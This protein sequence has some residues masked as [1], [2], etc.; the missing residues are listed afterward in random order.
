M[1]AITH[2]LT[3][4]L[5]AKAFFSNKHGRVGTAAV[6]IG[7]VFPDSDVIF[8]LFTANRLATME[9]HRGVT[10]SYLAL[11]LFAALLAGVTK[12]FAPQKKF[13]S[14][15]S[16]YALGLAVHIFLDLITSWGTMIWSPLNKTRASLDLV[17][18]IDFIFVALVLFPQV[19][20]WVYAVRAGAMRRVLLVWLLATVLAIGMADLATEL[21]EITFPW[22]P[23]LLASAAVAAVFLLP[24]AG[25]WGFRQPRALFCR[26]G[27]ATL[28]AY[29]A[30][31]SVNHFFALKRV[32]EF[33][34]RDKLLVER[35]A[36]LPMPLSPFSWT[37]LVLTPA[38]VYESRFS[39][40]SNA[41]SEFRF[42]PTAPP[43]RYIALAQ[44]VPATQ[45]YLWFARFPVVRYRNA[46][47][48]HIVEYADMR[49]SSSRNRRSPF[50]Y[51]VLLNSQG[52]VLMA[53]FLRR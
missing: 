47:E 51:R 23:V 20:A 24:C 34:A 27:V 21:A 38:G 26:I 7:A 13:L 32:E 46:G 16:L 1:D 18:F 36:A 15:W 3:G 28:V 11:P 35:L 22:Q 37:G 44:A 30:L 14:L 41:P 33:A 12:R 9:L 6:T 17:S 40:L 53:D 2:G 31:C 5:V 25:G 52:K 49:S 19:L 4:A 10:H 8:G 43:N 50:R 39:V 29:F 48:L 45:T 42:F